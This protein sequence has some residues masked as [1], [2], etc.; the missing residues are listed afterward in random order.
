M[1]NFRD[2]R[3]T[4]I[5][6]MATIILAIISYLYVE[7]TTRVAA[8]EKRLGDHAERMSRLEII[9]EGQREINKDLKDIVRS[10]TEQQR[11]TL[12]PPLAR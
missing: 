4:M 1:N 8:A 3:N 10:L 5:A 6:G 9:V 12:T 2:F 11:F 7:Q